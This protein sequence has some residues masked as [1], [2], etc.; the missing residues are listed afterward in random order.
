MQT[1]SMF[2]SEDAGD[3]FSK[4]DDSQFA[5]W[6]KNNPGAAAKAD[7]MRKKAQEGS[8][9]KPNKYDQA[10]K[11]LPGD[12]GGALAK[13]SG[14]F[15]Q[16]LK[17]KAK[18]VAMSQAKK[19]G[20]ALVKKG[21]ETIADKIRKKDMGK[22]SQGIKNSPDKQKDASG[23]AGEPELKGQQAKDTKA[24]ED[25]GKYRM[26]KDDIT[27]ALRDYDSEKEAKAKEKEEAEKKKG[28]RDNLK[29]RWEDSIFK[30]KKKQADAIYDAPGKLGRFLANKLRST[31]KDDGGPAF[32]QELR[33][34]QSR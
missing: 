19:A 5:D 29:D 30:N 1:Y 13:T 6:K 23:S 3:K 14:G 33:G 4:M 28:V 15:K 27:G 26:S 16:Q 34:A 7:A 31:V 9:P 11:S 20:S 32:G 10:K 8:A 25:A 24:R 12:K 17:L 22:W 18:E 21:K 2:F